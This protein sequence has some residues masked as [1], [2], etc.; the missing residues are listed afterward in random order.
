MRRAMA[1]MSPSV[2]S[3]T[4]MAFPPGVFITR[5][6]AAVAASRSTLSTPTPARPMT[7]SLGACS[8]TA[9]ST[10]TTL[11]TSKASQSARCREYSLG[12]ET[13][14]SQPGCARNNS[15]PGAARGSAIRIL[16]M[17]GLLGLLGLLVDFLDRRHARTIFHRQTVGFEDDFEL[18]DN[19]EQVR[20]IEVA[21]MRNAEDLALHRSLAVGDDGAE[22]IAEFL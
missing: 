21:Q 22:A 7:R 9:R 3:A 15:I 13:T 11:R 12:L 6:P 1:S 10:C 2:C 8:S 14:T 20:E 4:E 18:R 5:T 17:L 16:G 19:G